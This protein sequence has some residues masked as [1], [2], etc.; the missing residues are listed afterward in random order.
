M[1][2]VKRVSA[3]GWVVYWS[4]CLLG[5]FVARGL[6][7]NLLVSNAPCYVFGKLITFVMFASPAV[8]WCEVP[9]YPSS[10]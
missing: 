3:T 6:I 7:R 10:L 9:S 2:I 8:I 1:G 5:I 4:V